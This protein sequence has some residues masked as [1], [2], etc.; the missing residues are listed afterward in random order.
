[1]Q[2]QCE[3]IETCCLDNGR[4][5]DPRS[6]SGCGFLSLNAIFVGFDLHDPRLLEA[7]KTVHRDEAPAGF[8]PWLDKNLGHYD[9]VAR[10]W[11]LRDSLP[12]SFRNQ[13]S[14]KC[15]DGRC[16]H[17][18]YGF[19][20]YEDRDRHF[21]EHSMLLKRD[22]GLSVSGTPPLLF[23]EHPSG[24]SYSEFPKQSSPSFLPRPAS[25]QLAPIPGSSQPRDHR[26]SLR[27]YSFVSE[28]PGHHP[29]GSIDSEVDPLLPPLKRSRTGQPTGRLESIDELRLRRDIPSCL[30]CK[31]LM[32]P[33]GSISSMIHARL[34]TWLCSAM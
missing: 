11:R 18:I 6:T 8:G 9:P 5:P 29:R 10:S 12:M 22:S 31:V 28:H 15:W 1:L 2:Y 7:L 23:P 24:S 17:Y 27:S 34:L 20:H 4:W 21:K 25:T 33:V 13:H 26:D 19:P 3:C 30:R 14:Y 32:K 16:M